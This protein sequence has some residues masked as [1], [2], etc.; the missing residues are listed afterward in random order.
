MSRRKSYLQLEEGISNLKHQN[1]G[2]AV[3]MADQDALAGAAHA[4]NL[5]LLFQAV[6]SLHNRVV[7][8]GL[9]LLRTKSVVR[10]G[11]ES[12][13]LWLTSREGTRHNRPECWQQVRHSW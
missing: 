11:I 4:M 6:Q 13:G 12:E 3:L 7:L 10:K 2:N 1:V 5:I 9:V 8:L